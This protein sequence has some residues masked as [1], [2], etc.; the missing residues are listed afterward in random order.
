[1]WATKL[2]SVF[3]MVI[4]GK[5]PT[6]EIEVKHGEERWHQWIHE[7]ANTDR[8]DQKPRSFW[9]LTALRFK[10]IF[11]RS[12]EWFFPWPTC[13]VPFPSGWT[14]QTCIFSTAPFFL[15]Q[16]Y[17]PF[18][19]N[20]LAASFNAHW[21]QIGKE[22]VNVGQFKLRLT[23]S[24][25]VPSLASRIPCCWPLTRGENWHCC[26]LK[27][28]MNQCGRTRISRNCVGLFDHQAAEQRPSVRK[29]NRLSHTAP[30]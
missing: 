10:H 1:M 4:C 23:G 22:A 20:C 12:S 25:Q 18:S 29:I 8:L 2:N 9:S 3:A 11:N 27:K 17:S 7:D 24:S 26:L 16:Q 30:P 5:V 6:N 28:A 14:Q 19:G 21:E 15:K 13:Y